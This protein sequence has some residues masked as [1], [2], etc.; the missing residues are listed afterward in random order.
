MSSSDIEYTVLNIEEIP[1]NF[2]AG[3]PL[4]KTLDLWRGWAGDRTAPDWR[5]VELYVLPSIIL[6]QTLVV[7][8]INGGEDF[9]YRFW[10]TNYTDHYGIDETGMLLSKSLG[11]SFI[12][13]TQQQLKIVMDRK[14][15]CA[16]DV[17]IKA[18]RSGVV[19]SKINL[20]LPIMDTPDEVTKIMTATLFE[21]TTIKRKSRLQEAFSDDIKR[22]QN[23]YEI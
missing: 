22:R 7:D 3:S 4:A 12:D 15:P 23:D 14:V 8:A 5:S 13:A 21:E 19:Q 6:P 17:T 9:R 10:G 2:P 20:R 16:F 18:P 11:P 1:C